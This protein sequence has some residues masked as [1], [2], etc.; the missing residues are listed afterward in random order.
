MIK[1]KNKMSHIKYIR[2]FSALIFFMPFFGFPS[3][4][5]TVFYMLSGV[6]IFS[7]TYFLQDGAVSGSGLSSSQGNSKEKVSVAE[8][9]VPTPSEELIEEV[10]NV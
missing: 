4:W 7:L 2:F 5:K 10:K 1:Q 8:A 9:S 3:S 6:V